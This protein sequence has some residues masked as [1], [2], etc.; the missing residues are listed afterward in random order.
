MGMSRTILEQYGRFQS[1]DETLDE[2][3]A[4]LRTRRVHMVCRAEAD[5]KGLP[6]EVDRVFRVGP[7]SWV[8]DHQRLSDELDSHLLDDHDTDQV[9]LFCAGTLSNILVAEI[10]Q[11]V[12]MV[13]AIDLGSVFDPHMKL[14]KTR[15]YLRGKK[16]INKKC[17]WLD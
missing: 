2:T 8:N 9:F 14:G 4:A 6:F 13:T 1:T 7:N 10:S 17:I 15:R 5:V 11:N 16:A 12:P 3:V